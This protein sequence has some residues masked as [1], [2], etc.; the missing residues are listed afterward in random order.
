MMKKARPNK[1]AALL[2]LEELI[3]FQFVE[4]QACG[5]C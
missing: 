3:Q 1:S 5:V 2:K 4:L